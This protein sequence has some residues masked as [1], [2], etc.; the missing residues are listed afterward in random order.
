ML[1][2]LR[3]NCSYAL[4]VH[5]SGHFS[6]ICTGVGDENRYSCQGIYY[7]CLNRGRR[8]EFTA[9][10]IFVPA[11]IKLARLVPDRICSCIRV[12]KIDDQISYGTSDIP[13]CEVRLAVSLI[14]KELSGVCQ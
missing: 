10:A 1:I 4:L 2:R 11:G 14:D 13:A 5:F 12:Y 9:Y 7:S 3:P 6:P 8:I